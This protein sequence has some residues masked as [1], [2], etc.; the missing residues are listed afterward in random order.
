MPIIDPAILDTL[1]FSGLDEATFRLRALA[2]RP[3][4]GLFEHE[5]SFIRHRI[6]S[7]DAALPTLAILPDSPATIESYDALIAALEDSFNIALLEMP[8]FGFSFPKQGAAMGFEES[9]QILVAA[10]RDLNLPRV[11]LVG[12]CIQGLFAARIAEIMGDELAGVIIGQ[13]GDFAEEG[14]WVNAV[15]GG[16]VLAQPFTGQVGFRLNR[17]KT[18]IDYWIP[19]AAGPNAPIG[20]LQEEARK[21]QRAGCC[22]ALASQI[23]KLGISPLPELSVT[24]PAAILWGLADKSHAHTDRRSACKYAPQASYAEWR[25]I[26]HF[27]DIEAPQ[28]LADVAFSLLA[29]Q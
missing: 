2:T 29:Q 10:L 24:I 4:L 8:G 21:I 9:C 22:Y 13:T 12:P 17:A 20:A 6:T 16:A 28:Q 14:K 25:D 15:L 1:A 11:I 23:Q 3:G 18:S 5:L 19:F 26:G 27:I 7:R